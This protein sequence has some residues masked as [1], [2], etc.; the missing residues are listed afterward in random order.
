MRRIASPLNGI[1][2]NPSKKV[3]G[4]I[5]GGAGW[6]RCAAC[7]FAGLR[8]ESRDCRSGYLYFGPFPHELAKWLVVGVDA[9]FGDLALVNQGAER[10]GSLPAPLMS[11]GSVRDGHA[12]GLDLLKCV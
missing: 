7:E 3:S 10:G 4:S 6:P 2:K 9:P 1:R 5:V 11:R 8:W 12:G